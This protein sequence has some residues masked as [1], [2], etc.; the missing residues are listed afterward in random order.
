M[1]VKFREILRFWG[2]GKG[3]AEYGAGGASGAGGVGGTGVVNVEL[4][5]ILIYIY[6]ILFII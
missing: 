1:G 4:I 3:V 2:D 5:K 6:N